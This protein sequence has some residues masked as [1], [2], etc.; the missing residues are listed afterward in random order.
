[1]IKLFEDGRGYHGLA[2]IPTTVITYRGRF[3]LGGICGEAVQKLA[4]F[5]NSNSM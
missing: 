4:L 2:V 3:E 1:M 5:L